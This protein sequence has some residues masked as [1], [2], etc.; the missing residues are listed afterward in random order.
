V[1]LPEA[2]TGLAA[3]LLAGLRRMG[4]GRGAAKL[5][6]KIGEGRPSLATGADLGLT[7]RLAGRADAVALT[8]RSP[9]I[10]TVE[11]PCF[12]RSSRYTAKSQI[13]VAMPRIPGVS[14]GDAWLDEVAAA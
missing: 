6:M 13:A 2:V 12:M 7:A 11:R 5:P 8:S 14:V 1:G 4:A 9:K 3:G 10:V